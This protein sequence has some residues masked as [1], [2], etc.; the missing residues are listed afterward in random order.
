[1]RSCSLLVGLFRFVFVCVSFT[2]IG[3]IT[4]LIVGI[5]FS[6]WGLTV[7]SFTQS[8]LQFLILFFGVSK[9]GIKKGFKN[10]YTDFT[11]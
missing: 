11:K 5:A 8:L 10:K 3:F 1:M 2:I 7:N 4:V 6:M 9:F